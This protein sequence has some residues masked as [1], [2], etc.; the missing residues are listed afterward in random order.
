[1]QYDPYKHKAK[2]VRELSYHRGYNVP[3]D[4]ELLNRLNIK[5]KDVTKCKPN[6]T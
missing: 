3:F 1:M 2:T 6:S 5:S 4:T